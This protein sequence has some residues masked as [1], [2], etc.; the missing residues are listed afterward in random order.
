MTITT[1]V[2]PDDRT[3]HPGRRA[4]ARVL[5][6]T[7]AASA[8]LFIATL[9]FAGGLDPGYSHLSEGISALAS[10]ESEAAGVMT[11][12]FL[13]LAA[14]AVASGAA[15][16]STLPGRAGRAAAG[17]VVLAGVITAAEGFLRQS[18]S[19]LQSSCLDREAAGQGLGRPRAPQPE[20]HAPLRGAGRRGLSGRLRAEARR[21]SPLPRPADPG[22]GRAVLGLHGLVRLGRL[23]RAGGV[24]QRAF[25]LLAYGLPVTLAL[26][27]TQSR[28]GEAAQRSVHR[29]ACCSTSTRRSQPASPMS[30]SP[31][32]SIPMPSRSSTPA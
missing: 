21:A 29:S 15:L 30:G 28:A 12:G 26:V 25:V 24:V 1:S 19:S 23:R 17:L 4:L 32:S 2:G 16:L 6:V 7:A 5:A 11:V 20:R 8:I 10:D 27:T 14:A 31:P 13:F 18:C 3:A 22:R 9:V